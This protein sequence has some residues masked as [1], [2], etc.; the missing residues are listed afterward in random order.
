MQNFQDLETIQ[1]QIDRLSRTLETAQAGFAQMLG[2]LI[3]QCFELDPAAYKISVSPERVEFTEAATDWHRFQF[4]HRKTWD[5]EME[6]KIS[7]PSGGADA[8]NAA[9]LGLL[10]LMGKV[11]ADLA[12]NGYFTRQAISSMEGLSALR[13][14]ISAL[15]QQR[16]QIAKAKKD[17]EREA[18]SLEIE[19]MLEPGVVLVKNFVGISDRQ[20]NAR[21]GAYYKIWK[22]TPKTVE[23]GGL[24]GATVHGVSNITDI[25]PCYWGAFYDCERRAKK[26]DIIFAVYSG[27]LGLC[28][29]LPAHHPVIEGQGLIAK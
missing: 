27:S 2:R 4:E 16:D 8:G 21:A 28:S 25:D 10:I 29:L 3:G 15:R 14:K 26:E 6:T 1:T 20:R 18:E 22:V 19:A 17:A 12:A 5:G 23:G 9:H 24:S 7:H 13:S 11:A